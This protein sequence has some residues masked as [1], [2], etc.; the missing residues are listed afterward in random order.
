MKMAVG[1]DR[2]E[3]A[4]VLDTCKRKGRGCIG[5]TRSI[6]VVGTARGM[7][8]S[9]EEKKNQRMNRIYEFLDDSRTYSV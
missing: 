8:V 5:P 6:A 2:V 4:E 9:Q 1:K 7:C 3:D